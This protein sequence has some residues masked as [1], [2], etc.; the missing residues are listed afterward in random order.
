MTVEV[1]HDME[2]DEMVKAFAW[3]ARSE[4]VDAV[5]ADTLRKSLSVEPSPEPEAYLRHIIVGL[6]HWYRQIVWH[7]GE[8]LD[9]W[10]DAQFGVAKAARPPGPYLT[11]QQIE[12]LVELVRAQFHVALRLGPGRARPELEA[13]WRA[14][15]IIAPTVRLTAAFDDAYVSGRLYDVLENNSSYGEMM[16]AAG[17]LALTRSMELSMGIVRRDVTTGLLRFAD[18]VTGDVA[19]EANRLNNERV[20]DVIEKY[21]DGTLRSTPTNRTNLSPEEVSAS[22]VGGPVV[23]WRALA[24][25]LRNRMLSVDA[26]RDWHRVAATETRW[27]YNM[28]R[29]AEMAERGVE[30]VQWSVQSNA[31]GYCKRLLLNP[32][33]TPRRFRMA[34]VQ[35]VL[36]ETGGTNVGRTAQRIGQ[37]GGW[38]PT[39]L[40]HPWCRCIPMRVW[41]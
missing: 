16:R 40:I 8:S 15:G 17:G 32:D 30:F 26:E 22:E 34:E 3:A 38:L 9:K 24:R 25:E 29:F 4:G 2:A 7:I 23:G 35:R 18:G 20:R 14:M 28:G 39:A 11:Q 27:A 41:E 37:P 36:R 21:L 10:F 13:R 5:L 6:D 19:D 1:R 33:G 12:D 31:C